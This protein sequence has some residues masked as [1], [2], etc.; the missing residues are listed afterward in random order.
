MT[1]PL[2]GKL[3]WMRSFRKPQRH[4]FQKRF[5]FG[6]RDDHQSQADSR[7]GFYDLLHVAVQALPRCLS[8]HISFKSL[9]NLLCT[10][11][12][13]VQRNIAASSVQSLKSIAKQ[14]HAQPVT[15]G[16]A[17]FIFNFDDRYA[18]MS[19]GGML[20]PDHIESTLK[21]YVELLQIW[22]E[23]I[24]QRQNV[25]LLKPLA[26]LLSSIVER[27]L[28]FPVSGPRSTKSSLTASSSCVRHPGEF[29]LLLSLSFAS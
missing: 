2:V 13:H 22:I 29:E 14:G 4:P 17:R 11:T 1:I 9:V 20:G 16:F 27:I 12:A 28:I 25:L 3:S 26:I 8:P 23:E 24:T 15:V 21:L 5:G 19:D 7:Q 18:T 10:G 6:R